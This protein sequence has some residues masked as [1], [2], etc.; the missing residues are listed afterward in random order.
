M[1]ILFVTIYTPSLK[2]GAPVRIYNL[3]KQ[4]VNKGINVD[5]ITLADDEIDLKLKKNLGIKNFLAL[6][7]KKHSIFR[8]LIDILFFR[9]PPYFKEYQNSSLSKEVLKHI[10]YCKP[11][12]IQLE[13]LHTFYALSPVLNEIKSHGIKIVLD[14]HNVEYRAFIDGIKTFSPMKRLL[15]M[16]IAPNLLHLEKSAIRFS[17]LVFTCS[18]D[19]T[20]FFKKICPGSFLEIVPN[21]VDLNYFS[22]Q[23]FVNDPIILFAGGMYYPPNNDALLFYFSEIHFKVK[24]EIPNIKIIL[25]GGELNTWLKELSFTHKEI[26]APG[27]VP[28]VR[29]YISQA[30][31]CI[32]PMRRGSGTSLKI[33]EY[34]GSGKPIV[35]T[36]IGMRGILY[37]NGKDALVSDS[38]EDFATC[39]VNVLKDEVFAKIL[40]SNARKNAEKFYG[41]EAIIDKAVQN[42][43]NLLS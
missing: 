12:I 9:I 24:K 38:A 5:L 4:A 34:M 37:E 19:D 36:R 29:D 21:G 33:L 7:L 1:R 13:L 14:A 43:E 3:I 30:R 17:D 6:P 18:E 32:S 16:Y 41:W 8:Q 10:K 23:P 28:D 2:K 27:L 39:L 15:G 11:D 42:Y 25:L 22:P 31:V 20:Q 26:I 40:G 35:A